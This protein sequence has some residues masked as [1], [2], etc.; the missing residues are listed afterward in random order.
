MS[1]TLES[2]YEQCKCFFEVP[3]CDLLLH[4]ALVS[5]LV[6]NNILEPLLSSITCVSSCFV[7]IFE[8]TH[9]RFEYKLKHL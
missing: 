8:Q 9:A 3:F 7:H 1:G 4:K 5:L 2:G 6:W